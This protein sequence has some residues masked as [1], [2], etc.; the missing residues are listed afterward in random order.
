MNVLCSS[1][2]IF[3]DECRFAL[4]ETDLY[5]LHRS[6]KCNGVQLFLYIR[7]TD[8]IEHSWHTSSRFLLYTFSFSIYLPFL[9]PSKWRP[10]QATSSMHSKRLTTKR[11]VVCFFLLLLFC[12]FLKRPEIISRQKSRFVYIKSI[13]RNS[14]A[15]VFRESFSFY[16]TN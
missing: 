14:V 7:S 3:A 9:S 1:L 11:S 12:F 13:N 6:Q 4:Y 10:I 16:A 5:A 8:G 2:L 15:F